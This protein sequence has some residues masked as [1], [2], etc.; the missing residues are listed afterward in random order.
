M[1]LVGIIYKIEHVCD[2]YWKYPVVVSFGIDK[3]RS[4]EFPAVTVCS[5]NRIYDFS[6]ERTG[7]NPIHMPLIISE[8]RSLYHCRNGTEER[9]KAN[10]SSLK[11]LIHYYSKDVK[12]R[13][14]MGIQPSRFIKNCSFNNKICS[15]S[16]ITNF[17][18]FRYGNC[19][20]FNKQK[21]G[22]ELLRTSQIGHGNGL[23]LE[24]NMFH[25]MYTKMEHT[26]GL[27]VIIHHPMANP[28][29]EDDGF[30]VSPGFETSV[31]LRQTIYRR[32]PKP[33]KDHCMNYGADKNNPV[34]NKNECIRRCI[35]V[36]NFENC[37]CI[38]QSLGVMNNLRQCNFTDV[39]ESCCIDAVLKDM[40]LRSSSC[41]CPLPCI[42]VNYNEIVSRALLQWSEADETVNY[43]LDYLYEYVE[44]RFSSREDTK[45]S[46][47][48][49]NIF[50]S[51]LERYIY[52]QKPQWQEAEIISY[53]G[54]EL[55]LWLGLSLVA[56]F[57]L[58][59]KLVLIIKYA[60]SKFLTP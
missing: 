37:R 3:V 39:T 34:R 41:S 5:L 9:K 48:I 2:L 8:F 16:D 1:S 55:G 11:F 24:L 25:K 56:I 13:Y 53:I 47:V 60:V 4:L 14:E 49:L 50:Y 35:Q 51:T 54:N 43:N 15:T 31:S 29:A 12:Q 36:K 33:Y 22:K 30:I 45:G 32:L 17:T 19:I 23:I 21:R 57:E 7:D 26:L 38:D 42:S 27:K 59:E 46:L 20:I 44:P 18:N 40:S 6:N 10:D 58:F 28:S 52:E